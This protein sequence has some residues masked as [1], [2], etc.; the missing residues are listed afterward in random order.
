MTL[1]GKLKVPL[2][3]VCIGEEVERV[4]GCLIWRQDLGCT[5]ELLPERNLRLYS[6]CVGFVDN[7]LINLENSLIN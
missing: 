7:L 1:S 3:K 4:Q 5:D 2:K 6:A